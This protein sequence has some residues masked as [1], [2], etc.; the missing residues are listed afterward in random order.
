VLASILVRC[1]TK[2]TCLSLCTHLSTH[3]C[4]S[5]EHTQPQAERAAFRPFRARPYSPLPRAP[6]PHRPRSTSPSGGS[7]PASPPPGVVAGHSHTPEGPGFGQRDALFAVRACNPSVTAVGG[8][9][10]QAH[11]GAGSAVL[12]AW[13]PPVALAVARPAAVPAMD[14]RAGDGGS[15]A[16][17]ASAVQPV[18][19][20]QEPASPQHGS[21]PAL[22]PASI[23]ARPWSSGSFAHWCGPQR[24]TCRVSAARTG[25]PT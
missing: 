7:R 24:H 3:T 22:I 15:P 10:A 2:C 8:V 14:L 19:N 1:A 23:P 4:H 9:Q 6:A 18:G 25:C 13:R 16:A 17:P 20:P 5:P 11:L 21:A 12:A